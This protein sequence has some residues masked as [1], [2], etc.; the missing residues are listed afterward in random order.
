[1]DLGNPV[2]FATNRGN[3]N[4]ASLQFNWIINKKADLSWFIFG[5]LS[6][7][8]L[9]FMHV[10]LKWDMITIWFLWVTFV[11]TP[12]FF[13]TYSRT[14]FDKVEFQKRK[15]LL[16]G[17]L[18][19][20]VVG[21][22]IMLIT[23]ILFESGFPNHKILWN[24]FVAFF[25]TWA[26]W[27][28]VRQHYGFLSLYRKK[29]KEHNSIDYYIDI[30]TLYIGLVLPFFAFVLSEQ[31]SF[32]MLS[33][34]VEPLGID[35]SVYAIRIKLI[36]AYL[37]GISAA[38]FIFRQLFLLLN[39]RIVNVSKVLFL[40]AVIPL[41][42]FICYSQLTISAGLL[43][44]GAFVTIFHDV[45]YH[46]IIWFHHKNRY[47]VENAKEKFGLSS[48]IGKS[49]IRYAG[50]AIGVGILFRFLG[51]SLEIHPGCTALILTSNNVLFSDFGTDKLLLGVFFGIAM[52]HYYVDQFIWKTSKDKTLSKD[53]KL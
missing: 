19:F 28:V 14:Y 25:S 12:H 52:H 3:M 32:N 6:A 40:L 9:I 38:I 10:G 51:C 1:M 17:S 33:G 7:Y 24:V 13:G 36:L 16:L 8:L 2:I 18:A 46:A 43:G 49:F 39:Q 23:Y 30:S 15:R 4:T 34:L 41:H 27:H 22:V 37:I 53:L 11:D 35:L 21:P 50:C 29:G 5:A 20:L 26:Y 44:F 48:S 42:V 31:E 45:Q 47:R